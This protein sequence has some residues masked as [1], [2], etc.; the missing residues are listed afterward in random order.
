MAEL[1]EHEE[2]AIRDYFNSQSYEDDQATIIQKVGT[3][4]IMGRV[5]ELYDVRSEQGRWWVITNPTN[6]YSQED[7]P[8]FDQ[9]LTFH[10]GLAIRVVQASRTELE[11]DQDKQVS[12]AW[13]RYKQA[14]EAMDSASEST[15]FQAVGIMCREALLAFGHDH[16]DDEWVGVPA[17]PP[18]RSDFKGW[19]SIFAEKLADDRIRAYVKDLV[20]GTWDLAV[21]LQHYAGASPWDAEV[22]LGATAHLLGFFAVLLRRRELGAPERCPRCG[23]YALD[24][25][26]EVVEEP[27]QGF[28][29]SD[30][31]RSCEWR[32]DRTFTSWADHL[33]GADLEGH[34]NSSTGLSNRLH[35]DPE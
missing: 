33:E 5:H 3:R 6:L 34:L 17:D 21:W 15:H 28:L 7:F 9:A 29:K 31:C 1:P 2:R 19:G 18:K 32:S 25:D 26:V 13:R 4:R 30:V 20:D 35:R 24:E 10:L 16:A 27:E 8:E 22:V 14:V 12:G 11:G 23:S